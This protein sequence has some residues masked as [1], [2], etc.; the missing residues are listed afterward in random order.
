LDDQA[1]KILNGGMY[2]AEMR[3]IGIR[4]LDELTCQFLKQEYGR[5]PLLSIL[6]LWTYG[7]GKLG[8][9]TFLPVSKNE[10]LPEH[11]DYAEWESKAIAAYLDRH[12]L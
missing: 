3:S 9:M 10:P 2:V 8:I 1:E 7:A 12:N 5:L 4:G 6:I 11:V